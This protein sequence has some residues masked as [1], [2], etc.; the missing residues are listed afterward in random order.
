M[1]DAAARIRDADDI[2]YRVARPGITLPHS[3]NLGLVTSTVQGEPYAALLSM[4]GEHGR[5]L[6]EIVGDPRLAAGSPDDVVR[7]IDAGVAMRMFDIAIGPL[8][9]PPGEVPS[10]RPRLR[11]PYNRALVAEELFGGRGIPLAS[12]ATGS[13]I[14]LGDFDAAILSEWIAGGYDGL[15]DRLDALMTA[16]QRVLNHEGKPVTDPAERRSRIEAGCEAFRTT[17][18]PILARHGI[19]EYGV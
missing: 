4:L 17:L 3:V 8:P 15:P 19:V 5:R 9:E 1:P 14:T 16:H 13:A 11:S 7:A 2:W 6:S 18:M 10:A 12:P